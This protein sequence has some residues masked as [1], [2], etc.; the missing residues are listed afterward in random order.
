MK[1][2]GSITAD[3]VLSFTSW[4]GRSSEGG[5]GRGE[6]RRGE[7]GRRR[8]RRG[9]S[10]GFVG[11]LALLTFRGSATLLRFSGCTFNAIGK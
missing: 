5:E 4:R 2:K 11:H 8:G 1:A 3:I 9:G 10:S 7:E 6:E